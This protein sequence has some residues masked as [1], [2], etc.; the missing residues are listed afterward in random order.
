MQVRKIIKLPD[1]PTLKDIIRTAQVNYS[2]HYSST[3]E[4]LLY[5]DIFHHDKEGNLLTYLPNQVRLHAHNE[6]Y[7]NIST[8]EY[9]DKII[10]EETK[11]EHW[12]ENS[13]GQYD[14]LYKLV[15]IDKL[16]TQE[17][18][19]DIYILKKVDKINELSYK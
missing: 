7:V 2:I 13:I 9:V 16:F 8:G 14:Y 1:Y 3:N 17:E 10:N 5:V 4:L 19:E 11:E 12:P 18:L 6:D 15:N